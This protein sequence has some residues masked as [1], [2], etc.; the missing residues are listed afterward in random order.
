MIKER[1]GLEGER[2]GKSVIEWARGG[3]RGRVEKLRT[4][5]TVVLG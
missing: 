5:S 3:T 1:R 2:E 4:N